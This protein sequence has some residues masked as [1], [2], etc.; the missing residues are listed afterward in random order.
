[1]KIFFTD[2]SLRQHIDE[3][4]DA[5]KEQIESLVDSIRELKQENLDLRSKIANMYVRSG[6]IKKPA[7]KVRNKK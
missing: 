2:A 7:R 4:C 5:Y 1:M 3:H 6:S